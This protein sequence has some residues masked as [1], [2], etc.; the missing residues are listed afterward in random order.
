MISWQAW[1]GKIMNKEFL[2]AKSNF[3]KN[4]GT[5]IGVFLLMLLAAL[6]LSLALM[7]TLDIKPTAEKEAKRLEAGDG[8]IVFQ[9]IDEGINEDYMRNLLNDKPRRQQYTECIYYNFSQSIPFADGTLSQA[10]IITDKRVFDNQYDR[11]EIVTEDKS[12][13]A[14]YIYL[15]YQIHT[16]GGFNVGDDYTLELSGEKQTYKIKGFINTTYFGCNNTGSFQFVMDDGSYGKLCEKAADC[17][18]LLVNVELAEGVKWSK[19]AMQIGSLFS[20]DNDKGSMSSGNLETAL[21]D[22]TFMSDILLISFLMVT[23]IIIIVTS[24][25]LSN[26]IKNY[27]RENMTNLGA[28][29]AMG[30]TSGNLKASL[31]I[32]FTALAVIGGI[33]GAA[34]SYLLVPVMAGV[35]EGQAGVPYKMNFNPLAFLISLGFILMFTVLVTIFAARKLK[36]IEVV[37]ALRDG[38]EAHNFKKNRVALDKTSL[39]LNMSLSLKTLFTNL[40]QNIT[41]FFVTGLLVF[42]CVIGLLMY[43]NFNR[44]P[45]LEILTFETCGGV[46]GIDN[47]DAP[48]LEK[49]LK[50]EGAKN[51]R[52]LINMSFK[53]KDEE[54]LNVYVARDVDSLNNKDVVY[55]GRFPKYD[56]EIAIGGKFC[57][58]YG[59]EIGD[60]VELNYGD[61]KYS[62]L[63][64]GLVQTCNEDGKESIMTE[65]AAGH[66]VDMS[67]APTGLWFDVDDKEEAQ[68]ILD[69]ASDRFG[70]K[71][72]T[73]LNFYEV[74][75]GA[76]TTFRAIT[77]LML[78]LMITISAIVIMLILFL[79]I[80]SL[81]YNKKKDYGIY[82]ALGYTS[83]DL[84]LQTAASFMPTIILSVIIFS[85]VSYFI[86]NPYMQTIMFNFGMMKCNFA[87]PIPGIVLIDLG[88]IALSFLFAVFQARKIK[89][90]EAYNML[91]E[92]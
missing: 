92:N 10:L 63:I 65:E 22:K 21:S 49:L 67:E 9:T 85:V 70:D 3:R 31:L 90:I 71:L 80:K 16:S 44:N 5:S 1:D 79:F 37:T 60:E 81:L 84:I 27:I 48:E 66:L 23:A 38:M 41:T 54:W 87:I 82:K 89:N 34:A 33:I 43:E 72:A 24:L 50:D 20:A 47:E 61:K 64:T 12:I 86:A 6:L 2:L 83:K 30:F 29:K 28:L 32:M 4:R 59:Y 76:L 51:V 13:S 35:F 57:K 73:T 46:I 14:P 7:I 40:K 36:K 11:V 55:K 45:K 75:D 26:C 62:Y 91:T 56:N 74:M 78:S 52:Y 19:L 18:A 53:Y 39:P 15:P 17:K 58:L 25:M 68:R 69:A 77:T 8:Y 42:I 88:L